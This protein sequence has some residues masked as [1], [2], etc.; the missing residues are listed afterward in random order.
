VDV[1]NGR[2]DLQLHHKQSKP[3]NFILVAELFLKG[4]QLLKALQQKK[5]KF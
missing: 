5:S 3:F 1:F 4:F 2:A